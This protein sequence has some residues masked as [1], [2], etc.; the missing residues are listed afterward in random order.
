M[1]FQGGPDRFPALDPLM[2]EPSLKNTQA[3]HQNFAQNNS[4]IWTFEII[5]KIRLG[6]DKFVVMS[7]RNLKYNFNCKYI[8][9]QV[10]DFQ[11]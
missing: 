5:I 8:G 10:A 3:T 7:L 6:L 1:I 2:I 4:L 9:A 11:S